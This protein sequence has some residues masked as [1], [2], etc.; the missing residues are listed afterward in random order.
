MHLHDKCA[1]NTL[2]L[3][4]PNES[5]K[6]TVLM[7]SFCDLFYHHSIDFDSLESFLRIKT[8]NIYS[9]R[10][11]LSCIIF[12][13][14]LPKWHLS[15]SLCFCTLFLCQCVSNI[16]Y[17]TLGLRHLCFLAINTLYVIMNIF[18][19]WMALPGR[20]WMHNISSQFCHFVPYVGHS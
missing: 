17:M 16:V 9:I 6:A 2:Y 18:V 20:W 7:S 8:N 15:A 13:V 3:Y 5:I 19:T 1:H 14:I 11:C 4:K 10:M 12:W